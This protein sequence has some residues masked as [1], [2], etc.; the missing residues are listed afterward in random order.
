MKPK[1]YVIDLVEG[2]LSLETQTP[3]TPNSGAMPYPNKRR[4]TSGSRFWTQGAKTLGII[5]ST[6]VIR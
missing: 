4:P 1:Q 2:S 3:R 5:G 6:K